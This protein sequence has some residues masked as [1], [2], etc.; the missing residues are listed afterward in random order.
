MATGGNSKKRLKNDIKFDI[1]LSQEQKEAYEGIR[2]S[3]IT[4]M[5][6]KSGT[7]KTMVGIMYALEQLM[8]KEKHKMYIMRP[9]VSDEEIGYLPGSL[10][11][12]MKPWME[13]IYHNIKMCYSSDERRKK[14]VDKL[15]ENDMIEIMPLAFTRGITFTNSIIIVDEAQNVTKKQIEMIVSRLGQNSQMIICGDTRQ[16]DLKRPDESGFDLLSVISQ[17]VDSMS[18]FTLTENHRHLVVNEL[19]LR[20]EAYNDGL[21]TIT[22]G[23]DGKELTTEELDMLKFKQYGTYE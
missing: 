17:D 7:G 20:F 13:P 9:T 19:L 12:K 6:G 10:N 5:R 21:L 14:S 1:K 3:S 15:F 22:S 11:E 18:E 8:T 23:G 2:N 4:I 16:I